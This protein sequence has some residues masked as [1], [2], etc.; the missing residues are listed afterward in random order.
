MLLVE[1]QNEN[2]F[3]DEE[4]DPFYSEPCLILIH[5]L[6]IFSFASPP[7]QKVDQNEG[8]KIILHSIGAST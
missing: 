8:C 2:Y 5:P 7:P 6:W 4:R 3:K 1:K